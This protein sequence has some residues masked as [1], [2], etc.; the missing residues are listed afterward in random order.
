MALRMTFK[1]QKNRNITISMYDFKREI[2][3]V[4]WFLQIAST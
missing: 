4:L 1:D 3:R 2:I